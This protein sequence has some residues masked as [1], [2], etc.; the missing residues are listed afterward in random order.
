MAEFYHSAFDR[1]CKELE[2]QI[3]LKESREAKLELLLQTREAE[4]RNREE[5]RKLACMQNGVALRSQMSFNLQRRM[6]LRK[7]QHLPGIDPGS[8]STIASRAERRVGDRRE[9]ATLGILK[10]MWLCHFA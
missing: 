3:K 6:E 2:R 5:Q 8:D 7:M 10:Q 1:T 4:A 9:A